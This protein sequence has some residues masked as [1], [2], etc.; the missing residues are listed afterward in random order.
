MAPRCAAVR[1]S[2]ASSPEPGAEARA[3]TGEPAPSDDQARSRSTGL[4]RGLFSDAAV[5]GLGGVAN[6]AVAILLVPL[7]THALGTDGYGVLGIVNPT[8]SLLLMIGGLALPQA[9]F[10]WYLKESRGERDRARVVAATLG[11]RLLA[12]GIAFL[13]SLL[14]VVPLATFLFSGDPLGPGDVLPAFLLIAPVVLFDSIATIPLS[15]LRAE[16]RPASY[17]IVSFTRALLGS[18]LIVV[19]VVV[20]Q[21]G[22]TG[23]VLG[24]AIAAGVSLW[25]GIEAMRRAGVLRIT[26]DAPLARA[27]LGFS[28][29]LVPAAIAGWTLNL[30]DRYFLA[31]I[32]PPAEGLT[33][34]GT[35]GIYALGYTVGLIINALLVQPFGLAWGAA[36]WEIAKRPD[37]PLAFRRVL[38]AFVVLATLVATGLATLGTDAVRW[39]A[40]PG[41]ELARYV[42][43]F[44]AFAYIG[45][46]MYTILTTGLN[47]E[48]QTRRVP[49]VIGAAA[50]ANVALNVALIPF[51][52]FMGAALSTLL[53]YGLLAVLAGFVTQRVYP[54]PWDLPRVAAAL[55]IGGALSAAALVGPDHIL[56]RLACLV[57]YLPLLV[58][59][60]VADLDDLRGVLSLLRRPGSA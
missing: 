26:W 24:S 14:I 52:G 36:Y 31:T 48:S 33:V 42:I 18:A 37:A 54:V 41:F 13:G 32:G 6:Q 34:T 44:S 45:Y 51:L 11:L 3:L 60:R 29:P 27:M 4:L 17:G 10:R 7:Y 23:V 50:I 35:V 2:P 56:W 39:F 28:L 59:V 15:F 58:L 38:T 20:L 43:P 1:R 21:L 22:V 40:A 16:R 47:L 19:A 25:V 5:Y 9:F 30:S 8:L 53:S 55:A 49:L 12:S 57:A 46:G